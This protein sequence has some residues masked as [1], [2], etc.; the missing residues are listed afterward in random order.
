MQIERHLLSARTASEHWPLRAAPAR[1]PR[2][3]PQAADVS[4]EK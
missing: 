1:G 4:S 3:K 2:A